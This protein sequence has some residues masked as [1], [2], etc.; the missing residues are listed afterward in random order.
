[1]RKWLSLP[2]N[3]C[4]PSWFTSI[5]VFWQDPNYILPATLNNQF[6]M[7]VWWNN[8]FS[9][10]DLVHHPIET[11]IDIN[12]WPS[13]SRFLA[14]LRSP[15][16]WMNKTHHYLTG[17]SG[18]LVRSPNFCPKLADSTPIR[19]LT[20]FE[21]LGWIALG[22]YQGTPFFRWTGWPKTKQ[23]GGLTS[24]FRALEVPKAHQVLNG[25]FHGDVQPFLM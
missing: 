8:H 11:P 18:D 7:D 1:M 17:V 3:L 10:K 15:R 9:C 24:N 16:N 14:N 12:R 4:E 25:W 2:R 6:L 13:G 23:L 21:E 20:Q 19:Q 5:L 22:L